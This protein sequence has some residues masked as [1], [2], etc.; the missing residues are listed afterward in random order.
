MIIY[1]YIVN[2]SKVSHKLLTSFIVGCY[3][4]YYRASYNK[5]NKLIQIGIKPILD[6][7]NVKINTYGFLDNN[8]VTIY[9]ANHQSY[10]DSLLLKYLKPNIKTLAKHNAAGE[11]SILKNFANKILDNWGIIFYEKGNKK[12][13]S[14]VRQTIKEQLFE[15]QSI[16]IYPEGTSYAENGFQNFYPGAFDIAFENNINIQPITIKYLTDIKWGHTDDKNKIH[17]TN[18]LENARQCQRINQ[19]DINITFHPLINPSNFENSEEL[20]KY[21]KAIMYDEWVNQH[22]YDKEKLN[23][24]I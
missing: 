16:L 5:S 11:F 14:K 7:L 20:L 15:G 6:A 22:N 4:I 8:K 23:K 10:L 2:I 24:L 17:H 9:I 13:G 21:S 12:S 1:F 18:I 3:Y 19:N